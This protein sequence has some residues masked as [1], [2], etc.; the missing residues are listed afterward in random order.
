MLEIFVICMCAAKIS[1]FCQ[2]AFISSTHR[3]QNN[4]LIQSTDTRSVTG[5]G[6][7]VKSVRVGSGRVTGQTFRPDSISGSCVG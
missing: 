2:K 7:R 3:R 1:D 5:S 4:L 6:Y